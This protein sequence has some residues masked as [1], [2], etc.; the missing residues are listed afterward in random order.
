[1]IRRPP[2]STLFPYTTLFRSGGRQDLPALYVVAPHPPEEGTYVVAGLRLLHALVEHLYPGHH[3]LTCRAYAHHLHLGVE[4]DGAG[5]HPP[6]GHRA[7]ALDGEDVLHRQEEG[8][9]GGPLGLRD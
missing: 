8:P 4:R 9:I 2:R 3:R 7:P 1:M 6:R 5:L